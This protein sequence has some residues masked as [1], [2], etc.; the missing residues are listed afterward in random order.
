MFS[1]SIF[2]IGSLSVATVSDPSAAEPT[3]AGAP[4]TAAPALSAS[5][6][7][8]QDALR[9]LGF[10]YTVNES[11]HSARTSAD[12]AKL[13][14]CEVAQIAKSLVFRTAQTGRPVLVIASG[15][16]RVNEWRIG[17]LL[18]EVLEKPAAAFVREV[19]GYAIGGIPPLGHARPIE[20]FIDE[21]LLQYE[22]I[23]AA[24]G[25][26]NALFRLLPSDLA[27]MT[28]GRVVRVT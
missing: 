23:W 28:G 9:A 14:G 3:D 1:G 7:K 10:D 15:A 19:T 13:L 21:D 24:G 8:V 22:E 17:V 26:P 18:K 6:Q 5:A 20:T 4:P 27:K 2:A 16:N 11:P 12:A 25:T